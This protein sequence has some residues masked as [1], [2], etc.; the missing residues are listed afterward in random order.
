MA[1]KY[2]GERFDIHC[3]G[4]DNIFP[5]HENEIAQSECVTGG[6]YVNTWMHS[7]HLM[8]EK[9]K[10]SKSLD[11]VYTIDELIKIG[12]S[13]EM[14]RYALLSAHY[15]T[16]ISFSI[17][18]K[19][20]VSSSISRIVDFASRVET[21]IDDSTEA[22]NYPAEYKNFIKAM[23]DDLDSPKAFAEFFDWIR[24]SN[25]QMDKNKFSTD[26][27]IKAKKYINDFDAVFGIIPSKLD[28][29]AKISELVSRR[30]EARISKDWQLADNLR[31]KIYDLGW[32]VEDGPDGSKVK[33][34][35]E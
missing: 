5:H 30:E 27:A 29:P 6:T 21:Y 18:K 7:E 10:M 4:V 22:A 23:D 19:N 31:K 35:I 15:R 9:D 28:I 2:L 3:G 1:I 12:F 8:I 14:L 17:N 13:A 26:D 32:I 25:N 11:N 33:P 20:E 24:K 34:I 16:K